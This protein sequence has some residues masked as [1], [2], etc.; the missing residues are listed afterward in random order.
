MAEWCSWLSRILNS[1]S[2]KVCSLETV[3]PIILNISGLEFEPQFGHFF[4]FWSSLDN[5]TIIGFPIVW[6]VLNDETL[7][8]CF[9]GYSLKNQRSRDWLS[10]STDIPPV[11]RV[12]YFQRQAI[13]MREILYGERAYM[14]NLSGTLP[15]KTS[16][17]Q[18]RLCTNMRVK[19]ENLM[20]IA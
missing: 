18:A 17:L 8:I 5:S 6:D 12:F 1:N 4:P 2:D 7:S 16:G 20:V 19:L 11:E 9:E 15:V 3:V 10:Q 13:E 14:A